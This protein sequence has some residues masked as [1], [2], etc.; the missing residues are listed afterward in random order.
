MSAATIR[1]QSFASMTLVASRDC[2]RARPMS[3]SGRPPRTALKG[4]N[5]VRALR[6]NSR[7]NVVFPEPGGPQRIIDE[8][9]SL[10][11]ASANGCPALSKWA[12]PTT[13]SRRE[14]RKRSGSG[15]LGRSA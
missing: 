8:R 14:G 9:R 11:I 12:C 15:F 13:S 6:D 2:I 1:R 5:S 4:T 10:A 3:S 7:A